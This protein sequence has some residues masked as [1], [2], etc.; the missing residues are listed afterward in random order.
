MSS[1]VEIRIASDGRKRPKVYTQNTLHNLEV[2]LRKLRHL[3]GD[4]KKIAKLYGGR[5]YG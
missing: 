4:E 1:A 2:A 3:K 5:V